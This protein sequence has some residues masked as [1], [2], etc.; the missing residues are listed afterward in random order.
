MAGLVRE[1]FDD[2]SHADVAS[3]IAEYENWQMLESG[4][5]WWLILVVTLRCMSLA[6]RCAAL[7]ATA[8]RPCVML[9]KV[10]VD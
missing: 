10:Q 8:L 2:L 5:S 7:A 9:S 6:V 4:S 3:C 1:T